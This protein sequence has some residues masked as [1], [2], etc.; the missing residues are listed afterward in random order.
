MRIGILGAGRMGGT[1]GS[2]LAAAGHQV[3]F[4]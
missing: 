2:L 4:A 3:T 1:L